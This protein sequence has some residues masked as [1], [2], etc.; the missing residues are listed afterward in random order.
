MKRCGEMLNTYC[1]VKETLCEMLPKSPP[2]PPDLWVPHTLIQPTA[3]QKYSKNK[4]KIKRYI[5]ADV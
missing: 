1:K 5:V 2:P 4:N 3:D